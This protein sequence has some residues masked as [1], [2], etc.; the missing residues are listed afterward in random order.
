[1][2]RMKDR[3]QAARD[4]GYLGADEFTNAGFFAGLTGKGEAGTV[5]GVGYVLDGKGNLFDPLNGHIVN[6]N[7]VSAI[8]RD[9][10]E[11]RLSQNAKNSLRSAEAQ[12]TEF[13]KDMYNRIV[14][15]GIDDRFDDYMKQAIDSGGSESENAAARQYVMSV[16]EA[17]EEQAKKGNVGT[18]GRIINPAETARGKV[19]VKGRG[20]DSPSAAR[21]Y[22]ISSARGKAEA[23]A[24]E[25]AGRTPTRSGAAGKRMPS[26]KAVQ[27]DITLGRTP[28]SNDDPPPPPPSRERGEGSSDAARSYSMSAQSR[29]DSF[30]R[31]AVRDV[32]DRVKSGRGFQEGGLV[33][34]KHSKTPEQQAAIAIAKKGRGKKRGGLA[35]KK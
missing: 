26:T 9:F 15:K 13:G 20:E 10:D 23:D 30:A 22:I 2:Q 31:E 5:T 28:T 29:G 24:R 12:K 33:K 34:K 32:S 4:L 3:I 21:D 11:F 6:T 25:R 14:Q 16:K 18:D 17:V 7:I 27:P 35:S 8:S 19:S 1:M